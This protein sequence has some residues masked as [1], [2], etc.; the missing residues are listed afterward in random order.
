MHKN[1]KENDHLRENMS[2]LNNNANTVIVNPL[3]TETEEF[4]NNILQ[5]ADF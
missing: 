3:A 1:N 2:D 5:S 4:S